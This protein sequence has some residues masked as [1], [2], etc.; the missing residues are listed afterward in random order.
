[1][2]DITET[3]SRRGV[4]AAGKASRKM[5]DKPS[6]FPEE[7]V[8]SF[9]Q[10]GAAEGSA[11]TR[12]APHNARRR[13]HSIEMPQ[14]SLMRLRSIDE[15]PNV[16]SR[17]SSIIS[18]ANLPFARR[19]SVGV[20]FPGKRLSLGPWMQ[21]GRVSFSGLPMF[22]SSKEFRLEN[23]YQMGPDPGCR[24]NPAKVQKLLENVLSSYLGDTKYNALTSSHLTQSLS[25]LVRTK[26][27]EVTPPRYKVVCNVFLGQMGR[28]GLM[29]ASRPLW[30]PQNDSFASATYTNA[31]L[32]A[33]VM[34]HGVYFE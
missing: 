3:A 25:E 12:M 20:A 29:V 7:L 28:Q 16:I 26:V 15:R 13:S 33:V 4:A 21:Y 1:M 2:C 5:A 27:K 34:A 30:D 19:S 23:T 14:R 22:N 18:N 10:T 31:S 11:Q 6:R 32:F 9:S 8:A 17:R 24:F